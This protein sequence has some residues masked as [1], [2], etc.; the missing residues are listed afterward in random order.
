MTQFFPAITIFLHFPE[1]LEARREMCVDLVRETR[2]P[3]L[4]IEYHGNPEV[5]A[6]PQV[7]KTAQVARDFEREL[8]EQI[9]M[10]CGREFFDQFLM[11]DS[12]HAPYL[13]YQELN[14]ASLDESIRKTG[15]RVIQGAVGFASLIHAPVV[16]THLNAVATPAQWKAW[17]GPQ[18]RGQSIA[19]FVRSVEELK[20]CC[21]KTGTYLAL[22][23]MPYPF[24]S[25]DN[26]P[27]ESPYLGMF[28]KDF[29]AAWEAVPSR[30]ISHCFDICHAWILYE[31]VRSASQDNRALPDLFGFFPE[32]QAD[33][34]KLEKEGPGSLLDPVLP[35]V[36]HFHMAETKGRYILGHNSVEEGNS[37]D[38]GLIIPS[39]FWE[40]TLHKVAQAHP[41]RDMSVV[42]EIKEQD[43]FQSPRTRTSFKILVELLRHFHSN[44]IQPE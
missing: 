10:E 11:R 41:Q 16:T 25:I 31:T 27:P 29:I 4:G 12:V 33:A 40:E 8:L 22:E 39:G 9:K 5:F 1:E 28:P 44:A 14:L 13:P 38:D 3:R 23:N 17:S 34:E 2:Y 32:D 37:L 21:Q 24:E 6:Y 18:F 43:Y 7:L 36:T 20:D 19:Q 15:V 30:F 26:N 42:L 35:R